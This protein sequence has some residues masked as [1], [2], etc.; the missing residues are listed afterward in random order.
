MIWIAKSLYITSLLKK[1]T[2]N[3]RNVLIGVSYSV[4]TFFQNI[5]NK[6]YKIGLIHFF[7]KLDETG[8]SH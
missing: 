3:V 2:Y 7:L 5:S 6:H 1:T 8:E 4:T